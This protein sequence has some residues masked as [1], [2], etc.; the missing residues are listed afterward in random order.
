MFNKTPKVFAH[1]NIFKNGNFVLP[2]CIL[3]QNETGVN[4]FHRFCPHRMF[5]LADPGNHVNEITC[6]F[7]NFQWNSQGIPINNDKKLT[8]GK[9]Q[10]GRS[11]LIF[12]DFVEPDHSWVSDL[13]AEKNL[14]YS[15]SSQGSSNG[16]WLWLMDAEADLLH[17]HKDGIHPLL[18]KQVNIDD[19][20]LDQGDG[21]ILQTHPDGWWL[22][23]F[24]YGFVEY[25]PGKLMVNSVFPKDP[26]NEFGFDWVSQFYYDPQVDVNQRMIF[27]TLEE[28]FKE[29]VGTAEL[30]KGKY[31]PLM[32]AVNRYEDHCVHWGKWVREHSINRKQ[33]IS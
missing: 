11:G 14:V 5:P 12:K 21:W 30:Q 13:E 17:I 27:E 18:S 9:A 31:F 22:Y 16:S 29:D 7:H 20:S 28:V 24:P 2:D 23:I 10:V 15:H 32:N 8:C 4:L 19:L 33:N 1:K 6:K 25:G 26:N 3:N